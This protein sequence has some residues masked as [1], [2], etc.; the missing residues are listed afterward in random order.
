MSP[1]ATR[2]LLRALE[3]AQSQ[4]AFT[5]LE[6]LYLELPETTCARRQQCCGLLPPVRLV[7][8][9]WWLMGQRTHSA[10]E[11]GAA[12]RRLSEYFLL[13]ACRRL[14]CPWARADACGIYAR[15]FLGCR[16]YG[17]WSPA[18]YQARREQAGHAQRRVQEAWAGLGVALPVE[19]TAPGPGYCRQV[20]VWAGPAPMDAE[21]EALE[22]EVIEL[23]RDMP[24]ANMLA[25]W[26]G[27]LAFAVAALALG[28]QQ[29]LALK[30]SL[31]KHLLASQDQEAEEIL[32]QVRKRARD[33]ARSWPPL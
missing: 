4:G 9:A 25:P 13:N 33:W 5:R 30:V 20:R 12:A 28:R 19:V 26:D 18:A 6:Q 22:Q 31:T 29:A 2:A 1:V 3:S 17:L 14:P 16:T 15:C 27:D 32:A 8:M 10:Q 11:R 21:M 24:G 7:E 23:G